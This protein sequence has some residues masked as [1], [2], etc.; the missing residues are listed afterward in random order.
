M[1]EVVRSLKES[2]AVR[3]T[4]DGYVM[5][6][7]L[8]TV[9]VPST[10]QDVIMARIDRLEEVPKRTLQLASVIGREFTRRL[11]DHLTAAGEP[12]RRGPARAQGHRADPR[13]AARSRA[14]LR[15]PACLDPGRGVPL[16]A[17]G[18]PEGA[19]PPHRSAI[20]ELH[21][22][23][24]AEHHAALAHHFSRAEVWDKAL[25]QLLAAGKQAIKAYALRDA[26]VLYGQA[27]D[28]GRPARCAGAGRRAAGDPPHLRESSLHGGRLCG[29][30]AR[31]GRCPEPSSRSG[32]PRRR[33]GSSR[34]GSMGDGVDG[35]FP[36]GARARG[37]GHRPGGDGG[38]RGRALRRPAR[39][40]HGARR[41]GPA[42]A[43]R[44]GAPARSR[45][46]PVSAR[47]HV[48]RARA[49]AFWAS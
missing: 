9:V 48:C 3:R 28:G 1:E 29:G 45:H 31:G 8:D 34:T 25:A 17:A 33:G 5:A 23:R 11:L 26:L 40:R 47:R 39:D 22:D 15:V 38:G 19:A 7:R 20:E 21:A 14:G 18:A 12:T 27:R 37:P 24:I 10:I 42:R 43:R 35:G 46:R 13:D 36:R 30:A 41:H 49:W 4:D 16:A 32:R 6:A 2:G 44:S